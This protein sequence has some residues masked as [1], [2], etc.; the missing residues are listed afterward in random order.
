MRSPP[1]IC[2]GRTIKSQGQRRDATRV[3]LNNGLG[4]GNRGYGT[5]LE[6][7]NWQGPGVRTAEANVADDSY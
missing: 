3:G 4:R 2:K 7:D 5:L 1:I 6:Y